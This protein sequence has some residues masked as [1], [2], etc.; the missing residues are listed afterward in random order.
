LIVDLLLLSIDRL[1][2]H[3]SRDSL[4]DESEDM[5]LTQL[6][7][8]G[9][10]YSC[11]LCH[12]RFELLGWETVSTSANRLAGFSWTGSIWDGAAA[13]LQRP[14]PGPVDRCCHP[15]SS[16]GNGWCSCGEEIEMVSAQEAFAGDA[17]VKR[18]S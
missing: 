5:L 14:T 16:A 2:D 11:L 15:A 18:A 8:L 17:T 10:A 6:L 9:F 4:R 3:L 12:V 13:R 7:P 1:D